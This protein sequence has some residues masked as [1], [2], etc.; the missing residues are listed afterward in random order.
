VL[1]DWPNE[2]PVNDPLGS[3]K[4]G[5]LVTL[6]RVICA[7]SPKRSPKVNFRTSVDRD[8]VTVITPD[9]RQHPLNFSKTISKGA[10]ATLGQKAEWRV[11]S[12]NGKDVPIALIVR[13]DVEAVDG[14]K[15]KQKSKSYLA[16][17]KISEQG[18]CVTGSVD[19][20]EDARGMAD[21]SASKPCLEMRDK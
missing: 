11:I 20:L 14:K 1:V 10:F 3:L 17:A 6:Y 16:V 7:C 21:S 8:S 18:I 2:P 15:K 12:R 4:C 13:V 5:V 9:G 19:G